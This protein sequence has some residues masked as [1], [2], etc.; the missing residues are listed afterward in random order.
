[1]IIV[2]R[3]QWGAR[4]ADGFR[5]APVP[6]E[7]WLHHSAG[8]MPDTQ[9]VDADGDNVDDDEE[10]VMRQLEQTGQT[11]F[12][13]GISYT[14]L[15]PPSGRAYVG[16]SMHRQGAHT[17]NRND[18]ARGICLI[19]NYSIHRPTAMQLDTIAELMVS[20]QRAGRARSHTLNGGHR[21]LQST[22][23]PGD[24]AHALIPEINR[25]AE[26]LFGGAQPP[27]PHPEPNSIPTMQYGERS[28]NVRR[29]QQFM[30]RQFASYNRYSPTGFYGDATTAGIREFQHRV[31]VTGGDGR[32]VGPQTKRALWSHGFRG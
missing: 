6:T 27:P 29:L 18:R 26:V 16:H 15:V 32:N 24:H 12:K 20:E 3:T 7:W 25:R 23:C 21:D 5:D 17:R 4:F 19:G 22:E 9:W 1:M 8:L 14:W 13:G 30:T 11:R 31:G 2:T 10:K 28:D